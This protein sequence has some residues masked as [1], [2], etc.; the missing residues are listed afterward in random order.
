MLTISQRVFCFINLASDV[1]FSD[2]NRN[3]NK[4]RHSSVNMLKLCFFYS[5]IIASVRTELYENNTN[6]N[7]STY[8]CTDK[9]H[10]F[11]APGVLTAGGTNRACISR[12]YPEGPA[13]LLLTLRGENDETTT[14]SRELPPGDGGCLD[15]SVPLLPN[16]KAELNVKIKYPVVQ[17][18]WERHVTLR[19]SSGRVLLIHAE[20]ARYRPGEIVK[21]RI[22]GFKTDLTPNTDNI[23]EAW[24]EGPRGVWE[25]TRVAQW[26]RIRTRLGLTQL[27]HSLDE[28]AP[29]GTYTIRARL[30]DGSQGSTSFWVGHYDL[31]PFQLTVRHAPRVLR[32]SERLVWVVC[33]RYPWSEAV[34][35]MLVIRLR[36]AGNAESSPGIRTA[37][38]LRAPRACHRHAAAAKRVGLGGEHSPD[39]LVADFSFQEEGT[40]VW[41]NTTVVSQVVDKPISLEFL[42]KHRAVISPGLPYKLKVR[43]VQWDDKP[44]RG[45]RVSACRGPGAAPSCVSALTDDSGVASLMFPV[46]DPSP[47][48]RFEASL[49]RDPNITAEPLVLPVRGAALPQAELGPLRAEPA[50]S[51]TFVPLYLHLPS[52]NYAIT[53]HF[54]V[55]TRGGIIYRWG[56]TTQCPVSNSIDQIQT[57]SRNT[58]CPNYLTREN[59]SRTLRNLYNTLNTQF[60]SQRNS[61]STQS[62]SQSTQ[63]NSFS[64]QRSSSTRNDSLTQ[65]VSDALLDRHLLRIMLPIK[66]SHQMCPDSH[67]VAYFYYNGELVSA[68]KHF[69]MEECFGNKAEATW[70][71]R[72]VLPGST[73]S[74]RVETPGPALCALSVLDAAA[75]GPTPAPSVRDVLVSE[76]TTLINGHRNLTEYDA[77][78]DCFLNVDTPD[79]P[80]SSAELAAAWLAGAGVRVV[81]GALPATR[82]CAPAPLPLTNMDDGTKLR[83]DFSEAWLWRLLSVG[84][85]GT[86]TANARAPDS[87]TRFEASAFCVS[88]TG[89]AIS[90]PAVLQ[91]FRELFIHADCP[92]RLRRGDVTFMRYR[93]FNY[94]YEQISIEI[95]I[96]ADLNIEVSPK[97]ETACVAA[98]SSFAGRAEL[99]ARLAG[100]SRLQV[101][102]NVRPDPNCGRAAVTAS[103]AVQIQISVDPEGAPVQDYKSALLCGSDSRDS[104]KP[105]ITWLWPK[106]RAVPGTEQ[107]TVW[108]TADPTGPL[109]ADADALVQLPRGCGEQNM[110]RLAT[111]LLALEQLDP[112]SGAATAARE[113]VLRGF[114]RQL[115]YIHPSGGFSAFGASDT[116]S[117]TWLTAFALRYMKKA[118]K[119]LWPNLLP[120]PALD[121]A[122]QWLTHQ[123]MEN[124]CFRNEGQVF[125]RE[126]KGGLN[127]EGEIA[128]IALTAYVVTSLVEINSPLSFKLLRNSLS[129]L[130]A[131][132]PHKSKSP[133]KI[134]AHA[135][136]SYAYMRLKRYE[137]DLRQTN[138]AWTW[139]GRKAEGLM[140]DEELREVLELLKM[141]KR[142]GEFMWWETT[143]LSSTVEATGYA[144]LALRDSP[145]A[146][147]ERGRPALAWLAAQRSA[148]GG[149]VSTQDTLVALEA[150]IAWSSLQPKTQTNLTIVAQTN[151]MSA[152]TRLTPGSRVPDLMKLGPA[153]KLSVIVEGSGCALVQATRSHSTLQSDELHDKRLLVQVSV[154]TDG[155]FD[156]DANTTFCFCAA[157]VE[158]CVLWS[159][160]FPEM[161]LLEVSLPSGFGADAARLYSQLH[162]SETLLRRIEVSAGGGRATLY[163]GAAGGWGAGGAPRRCYRLHAVGPAARTRPGHARLRDYYRPAVNDTQMFT[164][165]EDCP[166]PV[167][168]ETNDYHNSDNLFTK[169]KSPGSEILITDEY[170]FEDIPDGIP[171]DDPLYVYENLV[172]RTDDVS[173]NVASNFE[174]VPNSSK[175]DNFKINC[176]GSLNDSKTFVDHKLAASELIKGVSM[177]NRSIEHF[178]THI[179]KNNNTKYTVK[180]SNIDSDIGSDMTTSVDN[181]NLSQFHVIDSE[182]DLDVPSGV[183]G[184]VPTIVLPPQNFVL[185]TN[186]FNS[187][188]SIERREYYLNSNSNSRHLKRQNYGSN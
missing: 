40:R 67:L 15:F 159:G 3:H 150:L 182:K 73:A 170:S 90:P 161:A 46:G 37:V 55:I 23:D 62:N 144:L 116:T 82:H 51:R 151:K 169:A 109:L 56:A 149:F 91:V 27:Q 164:I 50:S 102:A 75:K 36:G 187:P 17:C 71:T 143:S 107:V 100:T 81:G 42:T 110:A 166:P 138:E 120:P 152:S 2:K 96:T 69:E 9:N 12:F 162:K 47:Y 38:R 84:P 53:V 54:V 135:L 128:N 49:S 30:A 19:I 165:P 111:N 28:L 179:K 83:S 124:G 158:V 43:A 5:F 11:L 45:E 106:V 18:S 86:A 74:L 104:G 112:R 29:T 93:I 48:Y 125:H 24:I 115:Q 85:N 174:S 32:T 184:P 146:V 10:L 119:V 14:A 113:H 1:Q 114:N 173:D 157:V 77:S 137:E 147:R 26:T 78:G 60:S 175:I 16:T 103:D 140:E 72:Q 64:P 176:S 153:D 79:L 22:F 171:L 163:L 105:L 178:D 130:R 44:A 4:M 133:N 89:V 155:P 70:L 80:A 168:P 21:F 13:T 8:P 167:S 108:A 65:D 160:D 136:L 6:K 95:A 94:L 154:R 181:P 148:T 87:I 131:L 25:G 117:S 61:H 132:P 142:S 68:S 92:R 129:C 172:K 20:R 126:L 185:P 99:K 118:H 98:R 177:L 156:C 141:A 127:V 35:G 31:P 41:Q 63:S 186:N 59:Y 7:L 180:E 139:D 58:Q 76:L 122:E 66:I 134:Y 145:P 52:V 121:R 39:V 188:Q 33:V 57:A 34:E 97:T 88:K 101:R 183:E 123:Q